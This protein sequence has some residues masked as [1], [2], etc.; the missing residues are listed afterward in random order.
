[1]KCALI[2][3]AWTPQELFP[4]STAGSQINYWQPLGTLYIA[5]CLQ[6]AGHE[7]RFYNGA[8]ESHHAILQ[9]L[10]HYRPAF[11][12]LYATTFG[13][14]KA[15]NTASD[16]KQLDARIFICAG[17]PY[18]IAMSRQC[19]I[20]GKDNIDA[21]VSGE[22]EFTVTEMVDRLAEGKSLHDVQGLVF[23]QGSSLIENTPRILNEDLDALPFPA[24]D[25]LDDINNYL[26]PPATY[27]RKPVAVMITSRGC[28]RRCI[29]CSQIDRERKGGRRGIRFRSVENVLQEIEL[30]LQQG[31]KEIKF[32]DD[33]LAA[34]RDRLSAIC[35]EIKSRRLDFSW[36]ASACVNQVDKPLLKAMKEAGC[37]AILFGAESGVQK[38]LN[39]L[40]KGITL[41]QTRR[42]VKAAKDVG[43]KVSTPF[44]FGIP[45]ETYTD[46][47]QT[48]DFAIELNPDLANFHALTAF[49][50]TPLYEQREKYG[51]VT[52]QLTDYTYQ[53]ASF[54]PF[55]LSRTQIHELRQ[56]ALR[57]FYS[58]PAYLLR[59]LLDIRC[60]H[61]CR[62]AWQGIKS[63]FVL[64]WKKKIFYIQEVKSPGKEQ[65]IITK[66]AP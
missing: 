7:V 41:E 40:H 28:D 2:I 51:K 53:G 5:A 57:R 47:L 23:W 54:T 42:A 64:C 60:W 38:N 29:F 10:K 65:E 15:L 21:I 56:L 22:G 12:G 31:Y 6:R 3:P 8:F 48:I 26:P 13:W 63:L 32:I 25:L 39:T 27:R 18:P 34:D 11:V 62:F 20:D 50:G 44:V 33:T 52:T 16:I 37:W 24:R 1:M 9:Q 4:A 46:A 45:G 43:L 61:D 35:A 30:C 17:G 14:H 58:R 36:F 66:A 59:R 55:N 49:P 19:L